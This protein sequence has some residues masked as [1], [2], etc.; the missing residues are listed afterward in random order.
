MKNTLNVAMI[1]C[2]FMGRT[3]ANAYLNC[4]R[5]FDLPYKPVR[6]VVTGLSAAEVKPF[7]DRWGWQE[8][9]TDWRKV[10]E[11]KD[12]DLVDICVPNHM[13]H[14]IALYAIAAGKM[15]ACEKPLALNKHQALEMAEAVANGG[16]P[17]MIWFNYRGVPAVALAKQIIDEGRLGRIYHYRGFYLQDWTINPKVP[18]GGN[19]TWRLDV[20]LAGSG[21]TGDLLA[22][23]FDSALWLNGPLDSLTAMTETFIKERPQAD[24]QNRKTAVGID[25]A[26]AAL[27]RFQNGS[28]GIFESTRYACGRKS[29]NVLEIYG[30]K[31]GITWDMEILHELHYYNHADDSLVR[32]WRTI[33]VWDADHPYMKHWWVPGC[34]IGYEHT[35]I[36]LLA[37]FLDGLAKDEK[38][39]PDFQDG[40]A[41]QIVCDALLESAKN[42]QWIAIR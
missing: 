42:R 19:A 14:E 13:H 29:Q 6:K 12:I 41:T 10:I 18:V 32:G 21:V 3:H 4:T 40:L 1:G 15:I 34:Q 8:Y 39:A 31:G 17:N 37:D 9:T 22:H 26:A 2:G 27:A 20:N 28:L 24:D 23:T 33:S 16:M 25:D 30:E 11:R 35:F 36:H 7:A 5:F 38:K